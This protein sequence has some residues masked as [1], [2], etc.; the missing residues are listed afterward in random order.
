[1]F[2]K[3]KNSFKNLVA[4]FDEK[5][6]VFYSTIIN[7]KKYLTIFFKKKKLVL[8]ICENKIGI[9]FYYLTIK[10]L[11]SALILIDA[12]TNNSKIKLIIKKYDPDYVVC[13]KKKITFLKKNYSVIDKSL[14]AFLLKNLKKNCIKIN[15]NL[16]ILLSTSGSMGSP[17]LVMLTTSSLK[18]NTIRI[19]KYLSLTKKSKTIT[20]M[21]FAYS[22]MM[23]VINSHFYVGGSIYVTNKS[24]I[25]K[26]FWKSFIKNNINSFDGVPYMY[27]IISRFKLEKIFTKKIKFLTQAGGSLGINTK[28]KIINHCQK[29]KINFFSM[30]G[31]TEASPRISY[32][33]PKLAIKKIGSV[34]KPLKSYKIK[35]FD[36]KGN[37]IKK[38]YQIGRIIFF[39]KNIFSG[40]AF[41]KNDLNNL[42]KIKKLDTNDLGYL[43][44]N[45]FVYI[46]GRDRKL[47]KI[48]GNRIDIND[49]ETKM[50]EFKYSIICKEFKGKLKIFYEKKYN[51]QK[52]LN[53]LTKITN[54]NSNAFITSYIKKF[55]RNIYGKIS[56]GK[57]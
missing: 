19:S 21:P 52:I 53:K 25:D 55:P 28:K 33:D 3:I 51:K 57:L 13:H 8:I 30:Y 42:K 12:K 29:N 46:T 15:K 44:K 23:S 11:N 18:D 6:K 16:K 31:Q 4:I 20:S 36:G 50:S 49:L 7:K 47:A 26:R 48:Y 5:N 10:L 9:I 34:G 37:E 24:I 56:I 54:L 22:Y 45:D 41:E 27:E 14:D 39:G 40:Y 43:D 1:M 32:L 35:I 38:K 17:K 2:F